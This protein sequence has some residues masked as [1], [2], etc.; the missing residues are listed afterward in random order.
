MQVEKESLST[1]YLHLIHATILN[2]PND[3]VDYD[4]YG[5]NDNNHGCQL[6]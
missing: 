1:V 5:N 6:H 2:I 3:P 4:H